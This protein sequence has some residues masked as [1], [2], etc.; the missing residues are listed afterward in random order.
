MSLPK[1]EFYKQYTRIREGN[2]S[3]NI[4]RENDLFT[5]GQREILITCSINYMRLKA[6]IQLEE[7]M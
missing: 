3:D 6:Q 4:L 7:T 2:V 1:L 5:K